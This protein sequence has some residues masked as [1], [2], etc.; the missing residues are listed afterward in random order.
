VKTGPVSTA[1][2]SVAASAGRLVASP[3]DSVNLP[4]ETGR[5]VSTRKIY[6]LL[7]VVGALWGSAFPV[8]RY[9]IVSGASPILF[10]GVRY[11]MA[12]VILASVA[13][14]TRI[15]QPDSKSVGFSALAGLPIVGIYA[16]L[17]YSG[18]LTTSG[19]LT[20]I[21]AAVTPLATVPFALRFLPGESLRRWGYVGL[22]VGFVG[23]AVLVVPPPGVTLATSVW[24]PVEIVAASVSFA[25][26]T[27]L[28]RTRRPGGESMW[29]LSAQFACAAAF[30]MVATAVFE[31]HPNLPLSNGV[32]LAL[33]YLILVPA[34]V[35]N[36][37]YYYLHHHV[38][39]GQANV[40]AYV[41]PVAALAI[42]TL[43][44]GEP[45]SWWELVGLGLVVVGLTL[46]ARSRRP[47]KRRSPPG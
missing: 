14:A 36:S 24:G 19:G 18:E 17:L 13:A 33:A 45:F 16:L 22:A 3:I 47:P 23:V 5:T 46:L 4:I 25:A 26:G 42:G 2:N 7:A 9:G 40:V 27:V 34:V 41:N 21:L 1:N 39:P 32:I 10:A 15:P 35:G 8:I 30:L 44:L 12:A 43:L 29:G 38:G 6:S 31:P 28:L 37:L 11:G 20:A